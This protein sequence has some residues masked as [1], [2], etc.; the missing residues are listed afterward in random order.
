MKEELEAAYKSIDKA[1][2]QVKNLLK[3]RKQLQMTIQLLEA[4]G[5]ITKGKLDEAR[6][7][8]QTFKP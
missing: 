2:N 7:F 5:F 4:G 6:E 8:I 3:E 1:E